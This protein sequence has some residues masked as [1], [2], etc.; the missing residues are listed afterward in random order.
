MQIGFQSRGCTYQ[1]HPLYCNYLQTTHTFP[2]STSALQNCK[3]GGAEEVG[4]L[5]QG[6]SIF[7]PILKHREVVMPAGAVPLSLASGRE[8]V[9]RNL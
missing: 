1:Q 4:C 8:A 2:L 6:Q 7:V 5:K 9:K 3:R